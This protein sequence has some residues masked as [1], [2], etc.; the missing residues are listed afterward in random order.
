MVS[1]IPGNVKSVQIDNIPDVVKF[2]LLLDEAEPVCKVIPPIVPGI[3]IC[4]VRDWLSCAVGASRLLLD[5]VEESKS[6]LDDDVLLC[7]GAVPAVEAGVVEV[8]VLDSL[9]SVCAWL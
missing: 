1:E 3:T 7:T 5:K 9:D 8:P 2:M 4:D 6:M